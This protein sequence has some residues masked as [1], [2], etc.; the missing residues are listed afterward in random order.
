MSPISLNIEYVPISNSKHKVNI[1]LSN[2]EFAVK[3]RQS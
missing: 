2:Q 1:I 3:V